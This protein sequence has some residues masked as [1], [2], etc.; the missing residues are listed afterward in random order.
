MLATKTLAA[1]PSLPLSSFNRNPDL[2]IRVEIC[3]GKRTDNTDR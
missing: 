2:K 1:A 3:A